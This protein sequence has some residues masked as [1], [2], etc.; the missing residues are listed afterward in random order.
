[1]SVNQIDNSS[2][3]LWF[4]SSTACLSDWFLA[5]LRHLRGVLSSDKL[6]YFVTEHVP[7]PPLL[8]K[9]NICQIFS[10]ILEIWNNLDSRW[11]E[12]EGVWEG[13]GQ[14]EYSVDVWTIV[15]PV[16]Q[17]NYKTILVQ[18]LIILVNI[19]DGLN[20][21]FL[22]IQRRKRL[23]IYENCMNNAYHDFYQIYIKSLQIGTNL[24]SYT[25]I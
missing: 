9:P 2:S 7:K 16:F 23:Y 22:I 1:M 21:I 17:N 4:S 3:F 11:G 18:L 20:E 12:R 25:I 8:P 6:E 14:Y 13:G 5:F 24:N 15:F 10:E 19:N